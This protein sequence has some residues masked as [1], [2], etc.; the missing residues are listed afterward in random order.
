[1]LKADLEAVGE[2]PDGT[3]RIPYVDDDGRVAGVLNIYDVLVDE[4]LS[5]PADKMT[6]PL[7]IPAD[8]TVTDA[9]HRMRRGREAMGIV[10]RDGRHVG[11]VTIKDLVEEIVGELEAW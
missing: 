3:W 5:P 4:D 6:A 9:L 7:V 10:E 11:I 8:V 2:K 1:M